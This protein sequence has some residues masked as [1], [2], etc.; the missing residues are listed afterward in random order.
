MILMTQSADSQSESAAAEDK[1]QELVIKRYSDFL[2]SH[3]CE[4]LV[5]GGYLQP[6]EKIEELEKKV[7]VGIHYAEYN[8]KGDLTTLGAD[9]SIVDLCKY[10][11]DNFIIM[12]E[13]HARAR[14]SLTKEADGWRFSALGKPSE[15]MIDMI[16]AGLLEKA[17]NRL[18][19]FGPFYLLEVT[20]NGKPEYYP[21]NKN[22][23][24]TF[25]FDRNAK[26]NFIPIN[27]D[28]VIRLWTDLMNNRDRRN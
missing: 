28:T 6:E 26:G 20:R 22:A 1:L 11:N 10:I 7:S 27:K 17:D 19:R 13:G 24:E 16:K 18:I 21:A 15:E 8:L 5:E 14:L 4:E 23:V 25:K 9:D 3:P 12:A 2:R